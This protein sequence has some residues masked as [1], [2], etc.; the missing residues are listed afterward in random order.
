MRDGSFTLRKRRDEGKDY[1]N[2]QI[3]NNSI[4]YSF[5]GQD[6]L[7]VG[8]G[9]IAKSF[10]GLDGNRSTGSESDTSEL[11]LCEDSRFRVRLFDESDDLDLL[12]RDDFS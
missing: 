10:K 3:G 1:K 12:A 7:E 4:T 11:I 5:G 6:I 9:G 2:W 8:G